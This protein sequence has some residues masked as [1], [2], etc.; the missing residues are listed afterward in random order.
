MLYGEKQIGFQRLAYIRRLVQLGGTASRV[1]A[2][3]LV[4]SMALSGRERMMTLDEKILSLNLPALPGATAVSYSFSDN[5]ATPS[6]LF[7]LGL[8]IGDGNIFVRLRLVSNKDGR[9]GSIWIIPMLSLY[10]LDTSLNKNLY[11]K[12]YKLFDSLGVTYTTTSYRINTSRGLSIEGD[13]DREL[14]EKHP[15][16]KTLVIQG[17]DNIMIKI[18]PHF[19]LYKDYFY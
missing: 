17:I 3:K 11:D 12:L 15:R 13:E 18:V 16:M 10:Q 8:L 1:E 2:I 7:M 19:I 5:D 9:C 14:G 4:Y 6:F